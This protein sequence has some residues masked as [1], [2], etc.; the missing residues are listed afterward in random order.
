MEYKEF[1]EAIRNKVEEISEGSVTVGLRDIHKNNGVVL[2]GI[3]I[4]SEE[5][6]I[7]PVIYLEDF[8]KQY[9]EGDEIEEIVNEVLRIY[10]QHRMPGMDVTSFTDFE[11]AK[12]RI[13]YKLVNTKSNEE[14]L[15]C[16]PSSQIMDLSMVYAVNMG[17]MEDCQATVLIRN[18]HLEMW[19]KTEAEIRKL[20]LENTPKMNQYEFMSMAD[21]MRA[22]NGMEIPDDGMMYVLSN[23]S[24]I[25]GASAIMYDGVLDKI[26]DKI[27]AFFI[28]PSSIHEVIVVPQDK[29]K[30][31]ELKPMI[32][33]VNDTEVQN[34]EILSYQLYQY[35]H[36]NGLRIA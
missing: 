21:I 23:K 25:N 20:A 19:G 3:E 36:E 9:Q 12:D 6:R 14:M 30:A 18:E 34:Q 28:I 35:D 1:T 15:K 17:N 2:T 8:Y 4:K 7:A 29:T 16:V 11:W 33:E 32:G 5:S 31:E 27:G 22:M 26:E 24:R 13:F 10:S